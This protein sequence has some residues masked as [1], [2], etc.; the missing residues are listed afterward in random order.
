MQVNSS[1]YTQEQIDAEWK[2]GH[3]NIL[4]ALLKDG[5][6]TV[7]IHFSNIYNTDGNGLHSS[8]D[9]KGGQ[10]MYIQSE[11]YW[12]NRVFPIF[13]QPDLKGNLTFHFLAPSEWTI[14]S[15][16]N[17]D[18]VKSVADAFDKTVFEKEVAELYKE[19][20]TGDQKYWRFQ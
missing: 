2:Q 9:A 8:L 5:E 13:D 6:N 11:P 12:I 15:N 10:F 14:V 19:Q 3:L 7:K 1:S 4:P 16:T 20:W 18:L 17:T